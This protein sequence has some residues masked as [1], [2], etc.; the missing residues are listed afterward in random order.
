MSLPG[1]MATRIA[2][3]LTNAEDLIR[4]TH[5]LLAACGIQMSP[6]KISRIVRQF[7]YRVQANG[8]SYADFLANKITLNQE[9]RRKLL[10]NAFS[11]SLPTPTPPARPRLTT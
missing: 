1:P 9:Q 7:Q 3:G 11:G 8:W 2:G 10:A 4:D 6:S 5:L